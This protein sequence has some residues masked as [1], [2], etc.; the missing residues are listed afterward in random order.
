MVLGIMVCC[1]IENSGVGVTKSDDGF[2]VI[3][4]FEVG[5][6]LAYLGFWCFQQEL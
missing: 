2:A 5:F 6:Y 4:H 3:R 1:A